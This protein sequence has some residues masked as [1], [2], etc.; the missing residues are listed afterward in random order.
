[1]AIALKPVHSGIG[2]L[3]NKIPSPEKS[4][5]FKPVER[6][7]QTM[8]VLLSIYIVIYLIPKN[9]QQITSSHITP[10]NI[11]TYEDTY[12][13]LAIHTFT[14]NPHG[15]TVKISF[16]YKHNEE[17][18]VLCMTYLML[19]G[20]TSTYLKLKKMNLPTMSLLI[21]TTSPFSYALII[22]K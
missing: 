22:K 11:I 15:I 13:N 8:L 6:I 17:I 4:A 19:Y 7:V 3:F 20:K 2:Y 12:K 16:D 9:K 5:F 21:P 10:G 18:Q 14:N 1:M